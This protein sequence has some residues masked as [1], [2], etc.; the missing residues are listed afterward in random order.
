VLCGPYPSFEDSTVAFSRPGCWTAEIA[1]ALDTVIR[2]PSFCSVANS[3]G[4]PKAVPK[5]SIP[6]VANLLANCWTNAEEALRHVVRTK[7]PDRDEG[8]ITDLGVLCTYV[9]TLSSRRVSP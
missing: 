1:V 3:T 4:V 6:N 8:Y 9:R 5:L 7:C 2:I